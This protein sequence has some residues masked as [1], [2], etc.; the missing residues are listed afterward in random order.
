[1]L[2]AQEIRGKDDWAR[3]FQS[4]EAFRP[5]IESIFASHGL[6]F[7]Q[8]G[9]CTPG[10]N[11]VFRVGPSIIKLFAP[12]ESGFSSG[13]DYETERFGLSRANRLGALAPRLLASGT[14]EDRYRFDY[15]VMEAVPGQ[16]LGAVSDGFSDAEKQRIGRTLR[17]FVAQMDTPCEPFNSHRLRGPAAEARWAAFP[18]SFL[19][20]REAYL[21]QAVC[22]APGYI[23]GDLTCD[24]ILV[25]PEGEL[26]V[27]DYADAL[28]AP[29]EV[30]LACIIC[31]AFRLEKPYLT[32]FFGAYD[33][34]TLTESCLIGLLL[35]DFGENIIRD[36]FAAPQDIPDVAALRRLIRAALA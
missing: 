19:A 10:T 8:V 3:L 25:T 15:L 31:E 26:C 24:N 27:I 6:P 21:A 36:H 29:P 5:L 7:T 17:E 11:A 18:D 22:G 9:N 23:H 32:G 12:P 2:F 35:H 14:R 4:A 1:M 34:E 28:L 16:E 33:P 13:E 20:S 30:E